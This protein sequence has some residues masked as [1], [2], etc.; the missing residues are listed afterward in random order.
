MTKE[1]YATILK[2]F[3]TLSEQ[4]QLLRHDMTNGFAAIRQETAAAL[5]DV[6]AEMAAGFAEVRQ[7]IANI[8]QEMTTGFKRQD[9]ISEVIQEGIGTLVQKLEDEALKTKKEHSRRLRKVERH[10][11]F[12]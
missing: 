2:M 7:E 11:G 9:D 10:N 6:R 3:T 4:N 5:S 1:Q 8:R 12:A